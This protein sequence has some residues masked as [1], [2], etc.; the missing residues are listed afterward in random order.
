M[1]EKSNKA[2]LK[3]MA[4]I[5]VMKASLR[6]AVKLTT[7]TAKRDSKRLSTWQRKVSSW[8]HSLI[9]DVTVAIATSWSPPAKLK[10][11]K[12]ST[13]WASSPILCPL[14]STRLK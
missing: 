2:T 13:H 12:C 6:R 5:R 7:T 14:A 4:L 11:P 8:L 3:M 1:L 9:V 10:T